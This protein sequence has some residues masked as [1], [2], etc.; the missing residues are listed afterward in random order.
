MSYTFSLGNT[1][2]I[3]SNMF[4]LGNLGPRILLGG[5]LGDELLGHFGWGITVA[6]SNSIPDDS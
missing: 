3:M 6:Y 1:N 5:A 2:F 4:A